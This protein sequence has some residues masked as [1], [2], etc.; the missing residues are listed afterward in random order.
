ML[1]PPDLRDW[2]A[3]DD[4]VRFIVDAVET[5]DLSPAKINHRGSGDA[6]YPPSMMLA[7]LIYCYAHRLFSSRQ[8]EQATY[9]HV[10][11]RYLC[12]NLHPDHDTVAAFR[13]ENSALLEN[14]FVAVLRLAKEPRR[15]R[16][17]RH[18]QCGWHEV[19]GA[20][21]PGSQSQRRRTGEGDR[22]FADGDQKL[23]S[24]GGA[25]GCHARPNG[26]QPGG[27]PSG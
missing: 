7:L 14:C 8:I 10:S 4:L 22:P 21:L 1:L 19:R 13:R 5:C 20:R 15:L 11:V 2:V 6:Q 12:G 25:G 18:G 27:E 17:P 23:D 24:R 26:E 9:H 16:A 3:K